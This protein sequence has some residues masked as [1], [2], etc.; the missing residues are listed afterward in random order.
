MTGR[1]LTHDELTAKVTSL[2][3]VGGIYTL[4][5]EHV[6]RIN[7]PHCTTSRQHKGSPA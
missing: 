3:R 7:R 6:E 1:S 4:L 2:R 5:A